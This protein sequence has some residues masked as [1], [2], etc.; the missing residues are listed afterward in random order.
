VVEDTYYPRRRSAN[1]K[2]NSWKGLEA[3]VIELDI[4]KIALELLR[5]ALEMWK[6]WVERSEE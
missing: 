4:V 1:S 2:Y 6:W 3:T 5:T